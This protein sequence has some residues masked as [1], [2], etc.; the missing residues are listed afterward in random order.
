MAGRSSAW[1]RVIA[2]PHRTTEFLNRLEAFCREH[3]I[4]CVV[5]ENNMYWKFGGHQETFVILGELPVWTRAQWTEAFG[6][7]FDGQMPQIHDSTE[8]VEFCYY[9]PYGDMNAYF[10]VCGVPKAFIKPE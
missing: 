3:N 2:T 1:M 8:N 5:N 7:W 4:I 10:V 9:A 6:I